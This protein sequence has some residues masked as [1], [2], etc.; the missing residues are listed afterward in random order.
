MCDVTIEVPMDH[1]KGQFMNT[2]CVHFAMDLVS[3]YFYSI[4]IA[5]RLPV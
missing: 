5:T 2:G 4:Y 1:L 3:L